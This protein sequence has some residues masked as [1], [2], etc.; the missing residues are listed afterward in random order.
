M[1]K[2]E[3]MEYLFLFNNLVHGDRKVIIKAFILM[4]KKHYKCWRKMILK[5]F[6]LAM[7]V[8]NCKF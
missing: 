6:C 5:F 4:A 7:Q 1:T 8:N 2:K 3:K